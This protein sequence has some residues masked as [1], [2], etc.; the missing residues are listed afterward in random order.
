MKFFQEINSLRNYILNK[1][2]KLFLFII[3]LSSI[4]IFTIAYAESSVTTN[5]ELS[6]VDNNGNEIAAE[7]VLSNEDNSF[8]KHIDIKIK[9]KQLICKY[10]I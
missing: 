3:I 8:E 5:F 6:I 4:L 10:I 1:L 2:K 9:L 7:A